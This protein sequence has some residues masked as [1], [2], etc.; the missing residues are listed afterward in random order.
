[1]FRILF[2]LFIVVP[3]IEIMVLMQ[4][5]SF[6][7]AWPTIGIV[8]LTAWFGAKKVRQQ[9]LATLSSVQTKMAQGQMPS[10]EIVAGVLLLVSGVLLLTPGFVT[11]FFGLALLVPGFRRGLIKAV[12]QRIVVSQV[13]QGSFS[14]H[15][16]HDQ[17]SEHFSQTHEQAF[18]QDFVEK[19]KGHSGHTLEGDFERKD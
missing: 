3:I 15:N 6:L 17:Q 11:D 5:G 2:L 12:Q 9:G 4:V 18:R 7:G 19:P 14:H 13:P 1:M 8:I 10:D 16:H